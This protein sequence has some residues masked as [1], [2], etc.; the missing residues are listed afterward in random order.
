MNNCYEL[1]T[2]SAE[3][4]MR[5]INENCREEESL[6]LPGTP[7]SQCGDKKKKKSHG[8]LSTC[9]RLLHTIVQNSKRQSISILLTLTLV[10]FDRTQFPAEYFSFSC[11]IICGVNDY[12]AFTFATDYLFPF[13]RNHLAKVRMRPNT[14]EITPTIYHTW[15][16]KRKRKKK[17]QLNLRD[18]CNIS[19]ALGIW[20][21]IRHQ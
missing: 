20:Q 6:K 9:R 19:S 5:T 13:E 3:K 12:E 16:T 8:I 10:R 7:R 1:I 21:N 17:N 2:C 4:W 11:L 15:L 14:C 18:N